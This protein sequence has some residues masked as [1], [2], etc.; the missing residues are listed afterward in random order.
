[1]VSTVIAKYWVVVVTTDEDM[2]SNATKGMGKTD[3]ND[4]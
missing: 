4:D 2:G 1:M 3:E